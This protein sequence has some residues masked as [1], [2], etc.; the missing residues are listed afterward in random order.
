MMQMRESQVV[1]GGCEREG[2]P[3]VL[4]QR[5]LLIA[6]RGKSDWLCLNR[7]LTMSPE[8]GRLCFFPF[9]RTHGMN[10]PCSKST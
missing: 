3:F 10:F 5:Q 7:A 6:L 8:R 1:S 4:S 2:V 9:I